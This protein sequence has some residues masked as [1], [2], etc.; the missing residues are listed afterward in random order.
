MNKKETITKLYQRYLQDDLHAEEL[1]TFLQLVE[2]PANQP[3]LQELIGQSFQDFQAQTT[4]SDGRKAFTRLSIRCYSSLHRTYVPIRTS[5]P[6]YLKWLP[7]AAVLL[8]GL[9]LPGYFSAETRRRN[10]TD[11]QSEPSKWI[12]LPELHMPF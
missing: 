2:D 7:Y 5:K 3:I 12:L 8:L 11:G 6:N 9:G 1:M 4:L 10:Q